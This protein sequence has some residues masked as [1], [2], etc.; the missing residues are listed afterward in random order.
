MIANAD[1]RALE[2]IEMR[3]LVQEL[4]EVLEKRRGGDLS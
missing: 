1:E 4:E 2:Q 3:L